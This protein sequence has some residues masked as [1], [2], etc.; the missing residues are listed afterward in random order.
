MVTQYGMSE[1]L[2]LAT[3]EEPR[4]AFLN[5]SVPQGQ[6]EYSERTA[7]SIDGEI[8]K[9]LADAR[10]RVTETLTTKRA[11]LESLAK[12]LLEREVVDRTMLDQVLGVQ[13]A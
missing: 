4:T 9:L 1:L 3:F 11:A 2:G 8:A 10:A 13:G 6:R 5:I 7:E 12:L